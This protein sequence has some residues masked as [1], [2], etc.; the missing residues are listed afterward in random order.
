MWKSIAWCKFLQQYQP[1]NLFYATIPNINTIILLTEQ[2][3][4][5]IEITYSNEKEKGLYTN[6]ISSIIGV[7]I[8]EDIKIAK[9]SPKNVRNTFS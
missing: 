1:D 5:Q 2:V 8:V 7:N 9:I 4:S 3:L 6:K